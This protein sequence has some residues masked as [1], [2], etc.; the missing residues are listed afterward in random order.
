MGF[1][2]GYVLAV[3][4]LQCKRLG[5]ERCRCFNLQKVSMC[6][7]SINIIKDKVHGK[8]QQNIDNFAKR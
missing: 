8:I 7:N 6:Q 2:R 5:I 1:F 3:R 4:L